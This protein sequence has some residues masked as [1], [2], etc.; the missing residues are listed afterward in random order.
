MM[1]VGKNEVLL[2]TKNKEE[3]V[4]SQTL[5]LQ[6]LSIFSL[7]FFFPPQKKGNKMSSLKEAH[8][9]PTNVSDWD[10]RE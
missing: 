2:R 9:T 1:A 4:F 5:K 8:F 7:I 6:S 3:L 10:A